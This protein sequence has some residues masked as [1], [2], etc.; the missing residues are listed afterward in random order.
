MAEDR[1]G[2]S[3][4]LVGRRTTSRVKPKA[5]ELS[6]EVNQKRQDDGQ[7]RQISDGDPTG[8]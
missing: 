7:N 1:T 3:L 4:L 6:T 8:Q 2:L 5:E